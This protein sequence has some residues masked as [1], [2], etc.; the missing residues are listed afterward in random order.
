MGMRIDSSWAVRN[1]PHPYTQGSCYAGQGAFVDPAKATFRFKVFEIR[2]DPVQI[3]SV[4]RG[5]GIASRIDF[6][7]HFV[8]PELLFR[9]AL[10]GY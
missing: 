5:I 1:T 10:P 8:F 4:L 3:I 7:Q 6:A 9:Q 2:I